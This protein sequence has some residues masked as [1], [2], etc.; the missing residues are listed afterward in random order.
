MFVE[1]HVTLPFSL[2]VATAALD[3]ALCD[4]G[5]TDES[6]RAYAE[7]QEYL[8]RVGPRAASG[9]TKQVHVATL[10]PRD[11]KRSVVVPVRWVAT[12]IAGP[13]F[14]TLDANL[15]LTAA[16]TNTTLLS[17]VGSYDPPLAK[18]GELL[19]RA[20]LHKAAD[21]TANAFVR[22]VAAHLR[23][24]AQEIEPE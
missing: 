1:A 23:E 3:V 5:L 9:I 17:V 20:L 24:L 15:G 13:L 21:A 4:G 19:D 7:G 18:V 22:S 12:G 16:G 6:T 10:P 2:K 11:I 8:L 14:P